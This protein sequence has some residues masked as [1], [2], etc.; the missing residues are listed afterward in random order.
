MILFSH[1]TIVHYDAFC[2]HNITIQ[3]TTNADVI[4]FE[5]GLLC[6]SCQDGFLLGKVD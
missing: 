3:R 2:V 6:Q 4:K 5:R 1:N